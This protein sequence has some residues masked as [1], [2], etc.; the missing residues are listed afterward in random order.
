MGFIIA[1]GSITVA[2]AIGIICVTQNT[3]DDDDIQEQYLKYLKDLKD[4]KGKHEQ[5]KE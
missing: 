4:R 3:F 2:S 5:K 1:I